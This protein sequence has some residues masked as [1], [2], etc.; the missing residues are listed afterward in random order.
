MEHPGL[1]IQAES[2]WPMGQSHLSWGRQLQ[3]RRFLL[4][5]WY[6]SKPRVQCL[7]WRRRSTPGRMRNREASSDVQNCWW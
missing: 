3:H 1:A 2:I 4:R 5:A 7:G 6:V